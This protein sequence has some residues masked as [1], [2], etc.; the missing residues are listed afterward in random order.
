MNSFK[1]RSETR[2]KVC[3]Q[4]F[5]SDIRDSFDIKCIIRDVSKNGC[6][7]VSSQLNELPDLIQLIPQ[8]FGHPLNGRIV[9]K[10]DKKAGILFM[11]GDDDE[12]SERLIQFYNSAMRGSETNEPLLLEC[13]AR[14]MGYADRL[15]KYRPHVK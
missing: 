13:R 14:P 15:A 11:S 3:V 4:A 2:K 1:E 5:V 9:W 12:V 10:K 8:G 6:M 7:I